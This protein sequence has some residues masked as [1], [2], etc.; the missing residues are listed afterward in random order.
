MN[1]NNIIK[2]ME[3]FI[4]KQE[5]LETKRQSDMLPIRLEYEKKLE[6][7][8]SLSDDKKFSIGV[9]PRM[10]IEL[11]ITYRDYLFAMSLKPLLQEI[12]ENET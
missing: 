4:K 1:K 5:L 9:R 11:G 12:Q 3:S 10:P 8:E 6:E 2:G 7:F